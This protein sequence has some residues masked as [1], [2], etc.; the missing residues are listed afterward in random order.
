VYPPLIDLRLG[1]KEFSLI[2]APFLLLLQSFLSVASIVFI[3]LHL[4]PLYR[5]EVIDQYQRADLVI[6][7]GHEPFMDGSFFQNRYPL[8]FWGAYDVFIVKKVFG[9]PFITFPQSVGP[10]K[11][12]IGRFLAKFIFNN[13]DAI[14]L[15]EDISSE[16]L[17]NLGIG[18]TKYVMAD[19]AFLFED[20]VESRFQLQKPVVG[21]SP[22]FYHGMSNVSKQEYLFAVS[23]VLDYLVATHNLNVV[24]LPSQ[25]ERAITDPEEEMP[26]DVKVCSMIVQ[27]MK[28]R[29]RTRIV[30]VQTAAEFRGL[31]GQLD[32]LMT[33]RMHPSIF[34]CTEDVPFVMIVY[35]H[36]QTGLLKELRQE[37]LSVDMNEISFDRLRSKVEF[38]W[39]NKEKIKEQL[40][41]QTHTIQESTETGIKKIIS[42]FLK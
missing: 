5:P 37:A 28:Y 29:D 4:K 19:I 15:R 31:I 22:C 1:K 16:L 25:V 23:N 40:A 36:K 32:L 17:G 41:S 21:V 12:I 7:S 18:A 13:L 33:T 11:T 6:S 14:L 20:S 26:N 34:A 30:N 35:E 9:K 10:F 8:L 2:I 27:N 42:K 3:K 24:F 38:A 39:S